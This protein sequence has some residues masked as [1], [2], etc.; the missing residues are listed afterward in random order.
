MPVLAL[1]LDPVTSYKYL[2]P[3]VPVVKLDFDPSQKYTETEPEEE[4]R[5]T[6]RPPADG[7]DDFVNGLNSNKF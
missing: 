1:I 3:T 5:Q 4:T 7:F 2:K 6:T